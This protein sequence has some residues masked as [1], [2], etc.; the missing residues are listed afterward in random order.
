MKTVVGA[1]NESL[2]PIVPVDF[3]GEYNQWEQV[4]LLLDTGFNG[5]TALRANLPDQYFLRT[6][7][8]RKLRTPDLV[9]EDY[10]FWW[11][12]PPYQVELRWGGRQGKAGLRLL[13]P[14]S[15]EGL[16]GTNQLKYYR[17]T[18]DVIKGG[19]VTIDSE[20]SPSRQGVRWWKQRE[21]ERQIPLAEFPEDYWKWMSSY[22]SWASLLVQ[23]SDGGWHSI[24]AN[25]DT[26]SAN[27]L[28]LPT[29][30]VTKLGVRL[31]GKDQ[32][33]TTDGPK[34][35]EKGEAKVIWQG[36][37]CTVEC[38]HRADDSPPLIGMRL[39]KGYRV[40]MDFHMPRTAAEIWPMRRSISS[41]G[42]FFDF[43]LH[44]LRS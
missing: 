10:D 31:P 1:M 42:S 13:K 3:M 44:R 21:S 6:N 5:D 17:V 7:P 2:V 23:D 25:I 27:G 12:R 32:I 24:L 19:S 40:T 37:E 30:W 8:S 14:P 33:Y 11:Q 22:L 35:V 9:L 34:V 18:V 39:L 36:K 41:M 16:L 26:G 4:G 43:L 28:S 15:A 29:Y 38:I 20:P